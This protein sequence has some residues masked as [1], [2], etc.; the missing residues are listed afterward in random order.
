MMLNTIG[1]FDLLKFF[2][3]AF[4]LLYGYQWVPGTAMEPILIHDLTVVPSAYIINLIDAT[5][6]VNAVG[7]KLVSPQ[8]TI[9]VLHGCEGFEV[10]IL[11]WSAFLWMKMPWQ[12]KWSGLLVGTLLIY[13]FNQVRIVS[14]FFIA[15][16]QNHWFDTIHGYL[17]PLLLIALISGFTWLWLQQST[18]L[19][20]ALHE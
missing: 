16:Y 5:L 1:W 8:M 15:L 2:A 18:R 14:L 13:G 3:L 7:E 20:S 9:S 4:A 19:S 17:A 10:M 12:M 11:F 6:Q